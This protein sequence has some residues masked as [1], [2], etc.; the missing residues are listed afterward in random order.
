MLNLI[1]DIKWNNYVFVF[2]FENLLLLGISL[3]IG[4]EVC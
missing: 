2:N 1:K 3:G 4:K